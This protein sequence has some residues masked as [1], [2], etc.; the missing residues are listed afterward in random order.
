MFGL[1]MAE[2]CGEGGRHV[3]VCYGGIDIVS[4][5]EKQLKDGE[6]ILSYSAATAC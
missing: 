1:L 2:S 6:C 3:Y 4:F 5:N